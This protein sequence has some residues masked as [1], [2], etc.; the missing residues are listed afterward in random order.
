[1]H[2]KNVLIHTG[3]EK[4]LPQMHRCAKTLLQLKEWFR[5][6]T[7]SRI[8]LV[9]LISYLVFLKFGGNVKE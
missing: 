1:M 9:Q 6:D 2:C 7:A 5:T 8:T 3:G 4:Q